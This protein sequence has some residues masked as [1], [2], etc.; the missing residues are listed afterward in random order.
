[1]GK[2]PDLTDSEQNNPESLWEFADDGVKE[3]SW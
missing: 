2:K 1:V 3:L